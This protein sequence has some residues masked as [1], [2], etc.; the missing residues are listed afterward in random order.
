MSDPYKCLH[1]SEPHRLPLTNDTDG[2][3]CERFSNGLDRTGT[4][5]DYDILIETKISIRFKRER[6]QVDE[7]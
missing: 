7:D 4:S 1:L 3:V 5:A 6:E 2:I